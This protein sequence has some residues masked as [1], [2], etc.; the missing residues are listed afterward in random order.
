M[1]IIKILTLLKT[2]III[3]Y[4]LMIYAI[5]TELT[6]NFSVSEV[7]NK[8][9]KIA[10]PFDQLVGKMSPILDELSK[11]NFF[12]YFRVDTSREC[13]FW[14]ADSQCTSKKNCELACECPID[15]LPKNW[16]EEDLKI[17]ENQAFSPIELYDVMKPHANGLDAWSFDSVSEN[18]TYVDLLAD[19]EQYTGY[20]GQRIWNLIYEENCIRLSQQCGDNNFLF[21]II[22]GMH[23]SVSSH[24]TEYFVQFKENEEIMS[25]NEML[26]FRKVGKHREFM[27]N[28]VFS[29]QVILKSF[30]RYIDIIQDFPID[31]GDF[32]ED[33][34]TQK[35]LQQFCHLF[36]SGKDETFN[37]QLIFGRDTDIESQ[38]QAYLQ[39]FRNI[40]RIMDCVD[41]QKCKVYGKMQ[42]LG[43]G[44]A[45]RI[46]IKKVDINLTRNE[47]VAVVNLLRKWVESVEIIE[48]MKIRLNARKKDFAI[49]ISVFVIF[50]L[51]I[52]QYFCYKYKSNAKEKREKEKSD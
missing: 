10:T 14:I 34:K 41:C 5:W 8:N 9:L 4:G 35:L 11:Q 18:A 16:I 19:K 49:Y 6:I 25:T 13:P 32:H 28:L 50:L 12:R 17:R 46:L 47:L 29:V 1:I 43:I 21:R 42:I 33:M 20:Q 52:I 38:K 39:Y 22:S 23:T 40:T 2:S 27:E 51:S 26:Y 45:L 24:L 7:S 36:E 30:I 44:V 37:E 3:L 15:K 31:T 48:R